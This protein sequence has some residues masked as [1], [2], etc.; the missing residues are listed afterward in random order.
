MSFWCD[1]L[2]IGAVAWD[3]MLFVEAYPPP[4]TKIR[5][6]RRVMACGGLTGNAL[7][8]AARF[9]V[10]SAY[11]GRLGTDGAS[12]AVREAFAAEGIN[13]HHAVIARQHGVV[14][15]TIVVA[16]ETGTRNV[17]SDSPGGTG[18]D[19]AQ[20]EEGILRGTKVLLVDHHGIK[21]SLRAASI[22]RAAG[23]GVVGDFERDDAPKFGELLAL[24]NHLILPR[25]FACRV[26]GTANA[27]SAAAA[28]W[29]PQ[30]EVVVVTCGSD[31]AWA[32]RL[33]DLA[34]RFLP[35]FPVRACD[36]TGCGDV[37]HGV[38]AAALASG[39]DLETR[40]RFAAA[41][42]ALKAERRS[43]LDPHPTRADIE[44]FLSA[45]V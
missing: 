34:P 8:A 26:T 15:S 24:V 44:R 10:R 40:L 39:L 6:Q 9:G 37:F 27:A 25:T 12:M 42:A 16:T 43:G 11:A 33:S 28:L 3:E 7:R 31:G 13:T 2:G 35:S 21:G 5:I 22:V 20:P 19:D 1:V 38:Y 29:T 32:C 4:D 18:A 23:G 36:T 17:F 41:A 45:L 30:R 14:R